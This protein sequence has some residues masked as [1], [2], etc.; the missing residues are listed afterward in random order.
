MAPPRLPPRRLRRTSA[1]NRAA[2]WEPLV[3]GV[4]RTIP[5][6]DPGRLGSGPALGPGSP[7]SSHILQRLVAP[8]FEIRLDRPDR[9]LVH[10]AFERRH[11]DGAVAGAAA[12]HR[13]DEVVV[14]LLHA[15][16]A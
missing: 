1:N 11:V 8:R 14:D 13:R 9:F 6:G 16:A 12:P 4:P 3:R 5:R 7:S 15:Q 10:H 2:W